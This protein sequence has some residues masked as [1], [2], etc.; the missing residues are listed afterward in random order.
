MSG[1]TYAL[2]FILF[3]RSLS[4]QRF[5]DIQCLGPLG[6]PTVNG[7]D[8]GGTD[9][10]VLSDSAAIGLRQAKDVGVRLTLFLQQ[11]FRADG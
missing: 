2:Y 6:E 11:D 7:P 9:S 4:R 10:I 3:V 8:R 5:D 1:Q